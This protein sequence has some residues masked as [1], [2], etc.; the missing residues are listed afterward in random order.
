[1]LIQFHK[2]NDV[3]LLN[4]MLESETAETTARNIIV[5]QSCVIV[6]GQVSSPLKAYLVVEKEVLCEILMTEVVAA[7]VCILHIQHAVH[8]RMQQPV[9][10]LRE[11]LL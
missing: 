5:A 9:F 1:M 3:L 7:L 8:T 6:Q 10:L 2:L 4:I 11:D